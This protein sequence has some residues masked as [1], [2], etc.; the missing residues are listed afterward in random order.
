MAKKP[1]ASW[2]IDMMPKPAGSGIDRLGDRSRE[3]VVMGRKEWLAYNGQRISGYYPLIADDGPILWRELAKLRK[4]FDPVLTS[5]EF[6]LTNR[7]FH[8]SHGRRQTYEWPYCAI[9]KCDEHNR[10]VARIMLI[11]GAWSGNLRGESHVWKLLHY[12]FKAANI[13]AM[14][15]PLNAVVP[16]TSTM[17]G[18]TVALS[19]DDLGRVTG[20]VRESDCWLVDALHCP[21]VVVDGR[22]LGA[23]ANFGSLGTVLDDVRSRLVFGALPSA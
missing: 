8:L 2:F 9:A 19:P 10:P 17:E 16:N 11:P 6:G 5:V 13:V 7:T 18:S 15:L 14:G 21:A 23:A 12:D 3:V 1:K 22:K 20:G 4:E